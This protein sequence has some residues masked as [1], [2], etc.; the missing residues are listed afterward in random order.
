M[1]EYTD[2][3]YRLKDPRETDDILC[4]RYIGK[5]RHPESRFRDHLK[6]DKDNGNPE[7]VEWIIELTELGLTPV[8][9]ILDVA[10][11]HHPSQPGDVNASHREKHWVKHYKRL[12]AN[13]LNIT[14][15][16]DPKPSPYPIVYSLKSLPA[17]ERTHEEE[18]DS[19]RIENARLRALLRQVADWTADFQDDCGPV[20]ESEAAK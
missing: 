4:T 6:T 7:K 20:A 12:G 15:A 10:Q 16:E 14:Y 11:T 18:I 1:L 17:I 2:Y 13:L 3:I 5:T 8:M 19:L 9:E